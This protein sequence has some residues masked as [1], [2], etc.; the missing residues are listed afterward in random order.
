MSEHHLAY[1]LDKIHQYYPDTKCDSAEILHGGQFNTVFLIDQ[2]WIFRFP[3]TDFVAEEVNR[4]VKILNSLHGKLP[5]PIPY[6]TY[7]AHHP[8]TRKL[9]FMGY[10]MLFGEPLLRDRFA[11]IADES[12]LEQIAEDMAT[13][14]KTLHS[15]TPDSMGIDDSQPDFREEWVTMYADFKGKLFPFMRPDAQQSVSEDFE[16]ALNDTELWKGD[17]RLIHGDFGTGNIL[18]AEGRITGIIDFAFC[19]Y[20][21]P[22]QEVGALISSYG[23]GFI[24]RIFHYYP[25]LSA[26]EP[27]ARFIRRQYALI[28]ALFALRDNN[29]ADFDDGIADYI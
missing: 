20:G 24:Q 18:Y 27:R 17:P 19:G 2:R 7:L 14:L 10:E 16:I 23:D 1:C 29:Q 13:F 21:D 12:I 28:Q 11:Q 6:V 25:D 22:A 15:I 26:Y 4:E 3:R 8:D 5:L 9:E